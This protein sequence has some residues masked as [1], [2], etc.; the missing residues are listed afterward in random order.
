MENIAKSLSSKCHSTSLVLGLCIA[1][2][3]AS[4][5][6]QSVSAAADNTAAA[7]PW[8]EIGVKAGVDYKGDGLAMSVTEAGARLHCVFQQLEGEATRDGLWLSS[9]VTN[10]PS[11]R[12][13]VKAMQIWRYSPLRAGLGQTDDGAHRVTRP[14]VTLPAFGNVSVDGN[15]VRFARPGLVEEYLVSMDGVRQDFVVEQRPMGAGELRVEL[16]VSGA[17]VEQTDHG[18][19][20]VLENSG[21]KIAYSRLR[22]TDATLKKLPARIEVT[23]EYSA[24]G[25]TRPTLAV[26]VN[27]ANAVYPIRIDPTFSDANWISMSGV[28]GANYDVRAAVV[29][30]LGNLYIG[31]SFK[32]VGHVAANYIAKWD[33][34]SWSNL[35]SGMSSP[36]L[37]LAVSG[38][39]VFAG[40]DFT[41]AGGG[42]ANRIAK[43][44]GS[45]W[46]ALGSGMNN[47]VN[48]LAVSGNDLYAGGDFTTAGGSAANRIAK[49]NGSSWNVLGS[50]MNNHV[51]AL[52]VSGSD[53]YAGGF[54]TMAGGVAANNIAKWDGSS[55]SA[56]G[57]G[58]T[59]SLY[60]LAV[61]GSD[62]YAGGS[63]RTA[64]GVTVNR[65]AKWNGSSWS[66]L[67]SG[68]ENFVYAL[69]VSGSHVYAGSIFTTAGPSPANYIAKWNGSSWSAL[70]SGINSDVYALAV[71]GSD[72]YAGGTFIMATNGGGVAVTVNRIAK[73]NG[74][75][76][77]ALGSG[78]NGPVRELVVSGGDVYAGGSFTMAGGSAANRIAR[79]DGSSWSALGAGVNS[80]VYALAISG[81]DV[82]VGGRFT[83]SGGVAVSHIAKWNGS[84]WS[85]LGAGV[86]TNV[87][88]LAVSDGDVYAGGR[89]TTA[90]GSAANR[91]AKWNGSSWSALGSGV[92]SD[93]SALAVSGSELF[94]GGEFTSA[95]GGAAKHI[96]RW[97]GSSWSALGSGMNNYV[98]ALVV[99]GSDLY[100]GGIFT[101]VGNKISAYLA[102][103]VLGDAPGY[104]QINGQLLPEGS[105]QL[106][107]TG[108]PATNYA[109][110]RTFN[111]SPPVGWL[112]QETNTMSVSGVLIITNAPNAMTNNFWRMRSVP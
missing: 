66:A 73:W 86:N 101:T 107:Y 47:P 102:R 32:V 1:S 71:S 84:S 16:A 53:L 96:G 65:I 69:A 77:V 58:L 30:G 50:G 12:F 110:D 25:M 33:G 2:M 20:M 45:S 92:N 36:V 15:T 8:S 39:D 3:A 67:G 38:S 103:A 14:T 74:S 17:Q 35:D 26:V 31:G 37:A 64:G 51:N 93:V 91:I 88:A 108:Y 97:N 44:N 55:W 80:D 19:Q 10:L 13:R 9:T 112:P 24:H 109:L 68:M 22:V 48:A 7:I 40:G 100:A 89:F 111:L 72:V 94:A 104:N 21:R 5:A 85:A 106:S 87:Y 78:I 98:Y 90:G 34:S 4:P 62:V 49:W 42:A 54:F 29:D 11:D 79:W 28:P 76:W 61:A 75:S 105:M 95:G 70:G 57:S 60:A 6:N 83:T 27:D 56:L 81:S 99:S 46:S 59:D 63:F 18:A 41:A 52:A 43:W 23:D 82:F